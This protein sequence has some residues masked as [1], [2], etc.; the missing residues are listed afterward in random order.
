MG[1][2]EEGDALAALPSG[3]N[4]YALYSMLGGRRAGVDG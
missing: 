1:V 3:K 4:P 2:D